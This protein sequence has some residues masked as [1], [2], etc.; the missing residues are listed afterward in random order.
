MAKTYSTSTTARPRGQLPLVP[1]GSWLAT[2]YIAPRSPM[3]VAL[4][5]MSWRH[6]VRGM[7]YDGRLPIMVT[8]S[9][10]NTCS[11]TDPRI[12]LMGN[13]GSV[14]LLQV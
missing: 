10:R 11:A 12:G 7:S 13:I 14:P 1:N 2:A 8:D 4:G 3:E 6:P 9:C 5:S